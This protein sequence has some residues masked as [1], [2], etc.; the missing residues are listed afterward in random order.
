[1]INTKYSEIIY[2]KNGTKIPIYN[3]GKSVDSRYNPEKEADNLISNL[4]ESY[5]F[6]VVFGIASGILITRLS[7][8]Y[9]Q[10]KIIGIESCKSDID[11]L[12]NNNLIDNLIS[13][14]NIILT[15]I[16]QLEQNLITNYVPALY[17]DLKII[18]Q[19]GWVQENSNLICKINGILNHTMGIISADYSVQCHFGKLWQSNIL[20]N[21]RNIR[22]NEYIVPMGDINNKTALIVAA[23][24]SLDENI[25]IIKEQHKKL[26]IITT[27]TAYSILIQNNIIPDIVVSI[28]GQFISHSHFNKI[29]PSNTLFMLDLCSCY[30]IGNYLNS[31][32]FNTIYFISGHPLSSLINYSIND[33][34]TTLYSGAGTVT[35]TALDLALKLGFSQIKILGA[36][37]SYF[38]GKSYSRG[39]YFDTIFSL[40]QNKYTTIENNYDNLMYRT[41]LLKID[42]NKCTTDVL[43]AYKLS[44][45]KY[46]KNNNCTFSNIN[47]IYIINNKTVNETIKL[48]NP[49]FNYDKLMNKLNKYNLDDIKIPLL[50]YIAWLRN[51]KK[52]KNLDFKSLLK[53]AQSHFVSYN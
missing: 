17:G 23:G 33:S 21:L 15:D 4:N 28:D 1:M 2:A 26:F 13:N 32:N 49:N 52:Y 51:N 45:E 41:N 9:P 30:T 20:N 27:D 7:Q 46:I 42:N 22:K 3:S 10:S 37:F 53:L 5:S 12:Q 29:I 8:K 40:S 35:I 24:P 25:N 39:T 38:N 14:K 34:F 44:L 47:D 11:F 18:E 43:N 16:E 19:R 50:P 48:R 31:H 6:F 36:D